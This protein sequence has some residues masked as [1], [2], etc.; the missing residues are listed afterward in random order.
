[1]PKSRYKNKIAL[2]V[3]AA[4]KG[5]EIFVVDS[6][7]KRIA[8]DVGVLKQSVP[9]GI[10]KI[11]FRSGQSQIDKLVEVKQDADPLKIEGPSVR[12]SSAAPI[13]QTSTYQEHHKKAAC[14]LSLSSAGER[15]G[16]GSG[17]FIFVRDLLPGT[18]GK[19]W[20]GLSI[21]QIDGKPVAELS[22]GVCSAKDRYG[23]LNLE[24]DPGIYRIRVETGKLGSFEMFAVTEAGWQ[25]QYFAVTEDFPAADT[26]VHRASLRSSSVLMALQGTGFNPLSE[27]T[28]LAEMF[29]IALQSGRNVVTDNEMIRLLKEECENPMLLIFGAHL[30]IRRRPINH[31]LIS[32]VVRHLEER[33][34]LHPDVK[35]LFLR[36]GAG[37]PPPDL[38]FPEPPMLR[39]SWDL[40]VRG[41]RRR[42]SLVPP[43]SVSD[44]VADG[45][46]T[47]TPWLLHRLDKDDED[48][49]R[50]AS[51]SEGRQLLELLV[52]MGE[53]ET[54]FG[55]KEMKFKDIEQL[56]P[57]EQSLLNATMLRPKFSREAGKKDAAFGF[58]SSVSQVL[59]EID[60]P[61]YAIAR[62]V[63]S[64]V[65]KLG[66]DFEK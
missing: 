47:S 51:F 9:P 42:M 55:T 22:D 26:Q 37:A 31:T 52:A 65:K 30:L 44:S 38:A 36:P 56:S 40:I 60:A 45:L 8:S 16:R 49:E 32:E 12:F 66:I 5:T 35:S 14:E 19:P 7:L 33:F 17:L 48:Y 23:C 61:N 64:L 53:G 3:E 54:T 2:T 29:R 18:T 1:M 10:Y 24:V 46:L 27:H 15:P 11:R 39:S 43:G 57:L 25:T 28:R 21:H 4:D 41:S 59:R 50:A 63:K 34:E 58:A 6:D 62:S 20:E 13:E